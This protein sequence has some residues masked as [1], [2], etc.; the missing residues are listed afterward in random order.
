MKRREFLKST[1]AAAAISV[2]AFNPEGLS[3]QQSHRLLKSGFL[4]R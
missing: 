4:R 1:A 3:S 2:A